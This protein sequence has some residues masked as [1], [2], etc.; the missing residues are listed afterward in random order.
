[1]SLLPVHPAADL[2][3]PAAIHR[4]CADLREISVVR[5]LFTRPDFRIPGAA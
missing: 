3:L 2:L 5:K 4:A 1:M